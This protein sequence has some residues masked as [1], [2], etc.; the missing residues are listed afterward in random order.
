MKIPLKLSADH[1]E[2]LVSRFEN[3]GK[4]NIAQFKNLPHDRRVV[5]SILIKVADKVAKEYQKISRKPTLFDTKKK[6]QISLEYFEAYAVHVFLTGAI[7]QETDPYRKMT[8]RTIHGM[9]D[10]H[11]L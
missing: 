3:T 5:I 2:Y 1:I 6:Y 10:P 8:A 11:M 7:N 4:I 9:I